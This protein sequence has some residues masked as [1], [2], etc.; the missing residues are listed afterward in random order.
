VFEAVM[1]WGLTPALTTPAILI[2]LLAY[3]LVY[4]LLP[5]GAAAAIWI[6]REAKRW[7]GRRRASLRSASA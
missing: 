1:L 2:G 4:F 5:L 7:Y 6:L 3:R